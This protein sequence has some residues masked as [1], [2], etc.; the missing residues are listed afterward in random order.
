MK[1][2]G[3]IFDL[4]GTLL[5]S[6]E[7]VA[8]FANEVLGARGFSLR[9]KEEYRYLA[10][11]GSKN[12]M[13]KAAMVD[14]ETLISKMADEFKA[15]YEAISGVSKPYVGIC[16]TIEALN[17]L[18]IKQAVLSN[19]P[20]ELTKAC[21]DRF[22][23]KDKFEVV[24]GQRDNY[25]VKPDTKSALEIAA[26]FDLKPQEI[27]FVGDTKTDML[28]A[29]NGGFYAVGVTWGFRDRE[30]LLEY[31]ADI[32]IDMPSQLLNLFQK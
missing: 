13:A 24:L 16:E 30:E 18:E 25:L 12:L 9:S 21:V 19:K 23:G 32:L 31:G 20:D 17:G 14:D 6:L 27:V 3:V 26:I 10:G 8:N 29:K 11:E 5:D 22:F 28:T 15:V 7:D 4:D 1:K 2:R